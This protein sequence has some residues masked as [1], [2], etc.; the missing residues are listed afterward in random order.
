MH[1]S[2]APAQAAAQWTGQEWSGTAEPA[3]EAWQEEAWS[4]AAEEKA[5]AGFDLSSYYGLL[6]GPLEAPAKIGLH[7]ASCHALG[8]CDSYVDSVTALADDMMVCM[9]I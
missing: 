9:F 7:S 5:E 6:D 3:A 4:A 1:C 8:L 2:Q